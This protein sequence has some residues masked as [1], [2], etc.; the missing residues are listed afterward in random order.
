MEIDLSNSKPVGT[1][2]AE[3]TVSAPFYLDRLSTFNSFQRNKRDSERVDQCIK[4]IF[5][6]QKKREKVKDSLK[7]VESPGGFVNTFFFYRSNQLK[8]SGKVTKYFDGR[9]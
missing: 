4:I 7:I 6:I 3:M 8:K 1:N 2:G 5:F 9:E